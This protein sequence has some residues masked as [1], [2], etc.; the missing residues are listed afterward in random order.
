[1]M[2][3]TRLINEL[4]NHFGLH[5]VNGREICSDDEILRATEGTF[6]RAAVELRLEMRDFT[7]AIRKCLIKAVK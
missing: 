4:R 3:K 6:G 2:E 1:M 5:P 7:E